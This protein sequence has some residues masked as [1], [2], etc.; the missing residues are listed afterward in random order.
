ML[1]IIL[2]KIF[3]ILASLIGFSCLLIMPDFEAPEVE[4]LS[5]SSGQYVSEVVQLECAISDNSN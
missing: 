3:I 2:N 1:K 5:H 4:I